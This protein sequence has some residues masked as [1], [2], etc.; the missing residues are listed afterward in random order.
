MA[1][2]QKCPYC[3]EEIPAEAVRCRYCRS[4]VA[5]LDPARWYRDHPQR[6]LAGVCAALSHVLAVPLTFVRVAFVVLTFVHLIGPVVYGVLWLLIPFAPGT[7]SPLERALATAQ[8]WAGR[9]RGRSPE[10][11]PPPPEARNG[12]ASHFRSGTLPG[13]PLA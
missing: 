3:A 11:S 4:R 12:G 7:P 13:G 6:R 10:D 8:D 2:T 1:E 9:F 5:A